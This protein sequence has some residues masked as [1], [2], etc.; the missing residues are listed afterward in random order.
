MSDIEDRPSDQVEPPTP[1]GA[2][3]R[4]KTPRE[5]NNFKHPG[6]PTPSN[7][8]DMSVNFGEK[9]PENKQIKFGHSNSIRTSK[10]T[11]YSWAPLSLLFQFKRAANV[12]FLW[13]S[14]LTCLPW[15]PKNPA[16]MIYTFVGVLFFTMLKELYEDIH[17]MRGDKE[18]NNK[19]AYVLDRETGEFRKK[20]WKNLKYGDIVKVM[21]DEEFCADLVLVCAKDD[22]IFVDTMN[23]D[24][25][26]NLKPKVV[27]NENIH[28]SQV[29]TIDGTIECNKPD[30]NLDLWDAL[31]TF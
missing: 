3:N 31:V 6:D 20:A 2:G 27:C 21:K 13:I 24:G 14:I 28:E 9:Q 18:V 8:K 10:Y 12:Y 23:L 26:T 17:R 4:S 29:R 1:Y 30:E 19:K 11:W 5:V 16:S 22:I 7:E 25:E 15:S